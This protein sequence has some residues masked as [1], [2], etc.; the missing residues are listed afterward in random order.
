MIME[1]ET[2]TKPPHTHARVCMQG[3]AEPLSQDHVGIAVYQRG[4]IR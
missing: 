1:P 3:R 4:A 2:D